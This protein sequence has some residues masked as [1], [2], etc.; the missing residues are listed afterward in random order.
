MCAHRDT[1]Y[2]SLLKEYFCRDC[3]Q[4]LTEDEIEADQFERSD[5]G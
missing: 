2:F 1:Y 3:D 4:F 5:H